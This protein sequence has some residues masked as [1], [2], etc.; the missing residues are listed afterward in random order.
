MICDK[1]GFEYQPREFSIGGHSITMFGDCPKCAEKLRAKLAKEAE[2]EQI[3]EENERIL[4]WIKNANFPPIYA[5]LRGYEPKTDAQAIE[6]DYTKPLLFVGVTGCGKT[7]RACWLAIVGIW[8]Y[9][10]T[11]RYIDHSALISRI[12]A[13]KNFKSFQDVDATIK[14]FVECDILII[15][16][17][18]KQP[19]T[20]HLFRVLDGRYG[21]NRPTIF[22]SNAKPEEIKLIF[23]DALYS[24]LVNG[25]GMKTYKFESADF[26]KLN[27]DVIK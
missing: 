6:W 16:E 23:G 21:A 1:C 17:L 14:E 24:R 20:N 26:R 27:K 11:A 3:R 8:Q 7:M 12:E 19:Y 10:K 15:D 4:R 13:A 25:Q 22:L 2:Q 18:D 5:N 9:K